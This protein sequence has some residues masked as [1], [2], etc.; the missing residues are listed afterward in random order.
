MTTIYLRATNRN[1][2]V[3]VTTKHVYTRVATKTG[4]KEVKH[5][6][7]FLSTLK[8]AYNLEPCRYD[9]YLCAGNTQF[10]SKL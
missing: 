2:S 10:A 7:E 1:L 8:E 3:K 9:V 4:F 6:L 5:K